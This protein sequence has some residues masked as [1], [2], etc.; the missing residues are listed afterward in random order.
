MGREVNTGLAVFSGVV[1]GGLG[2]RP[3]ACPKYRFLDLSKSDDKFVTGGG[4]TLCLL[5]IYFI[6]ETNAVARLS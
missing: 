1:T 2:T 4:T 5:I 3:S 6:R